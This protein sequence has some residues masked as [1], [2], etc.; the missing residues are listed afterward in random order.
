MKMVCRIVL[1]L[2]IGMLVVFVSDTTLLAQ[3]EMSM[4]Q[5]KLALADWQK[6]EADAKA[7]IVTTDAEIAALRAQM[8]TTDQQTSQ[9]WQETYGLM[10]VDEAAV[11]SYR[12][13]LNG[14]SSELDALAAL[15]PEELYKRRAEIDGIEKRLAEM[16]GNKISWLTEMEDQIAS[17]E[18]KITQLRGSMPK[19]IYDEY[20]VVRGDYLWKISGKKDIYADPYMWMRLYSYN[21]DSIK[22]PDKIYPDQSL[23]V[24]RDVGP[25][26][27]LVA[28]GD[29][30]SKIAGNSAVFG[31]PTKWAKIYEANKDLIGGDASRIYPY[32]VLR[33]PR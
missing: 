8:E 7:A 1:T 27:Y 33:I 4:D 24:Q 5:Y 30:L 9:T 6:R 31:D 21:R 19:A 12:D 26:E 32:S 14:L 16:K 17:I 18:G 3:E 13:Q 15:S 10:G 2:A 20:T 23:K 25:D 22:D 29:F 28:K 11:S